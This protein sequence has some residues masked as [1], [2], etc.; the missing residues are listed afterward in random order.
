MADAPHPR[1]TRDVIGHAEAIHEFMSSW[2]TGRLHH[3]W[4]LTG[5]RGIGKATLAYAI[6]RWVMA[7]DRPIDK[8]VLPPMH[9][10]VKQVSNASCPTLCVVEPDEDDKSG[11]LKDI[12]VE[13]ART[14]TPFMRLTAADGQWRV[15]LVDNAD[16]LSTEAQNAILKILEEPPPRCLILLTAA[17]PGRMLPT[18]RSR[19]R[20]IKLKPLA[21]PELR[22]IAGRLELKLQFDKPWLLNHAHGSIGQLIHLVKLDAGTLHTA[23]EK[24]VS[25]L[26]SIKWADVHALA[27]KVGRKEQDAQFR[28]VLEL[29][30]DG[31]TE[32]LKHTASSGALWEDMQ[33]KIRMATDR[34]L[35]RTATLLDLVAGVARGMQQTAVN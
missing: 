9:Q 3:A 20:T 28:L 31:I 23:T 4:L 11:Q 13:A 10:I 12:G 35:D 19:C 26:P 25:S 5:N 18:I 2:F 22:K 21:E 33:Q 16:L 34:H 7:A 14:I 24:I 6:A 29:L 30:N 15:V 8:L 17:L 1:S 27:E 32:K